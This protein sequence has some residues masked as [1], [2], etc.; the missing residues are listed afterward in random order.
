MDNPLHPFKMTDLSAASRKNDKS[1]R[2][3][4][5]N[6]QIIATHPMGI[7]HCAASLASDRSFS[8]IRQKRQIVQPHHTKMSD[9]LDTSKGYG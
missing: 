6:R 8:R 1:S 5:R 2:R 7:N 3:I 4:A 9:H